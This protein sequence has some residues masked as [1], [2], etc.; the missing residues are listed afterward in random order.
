MSDKTIRLKT[1]R[2]EAKRK[3]IVS[4]SPQSRERW[5]KLNASLNDSYK[6]DEAVALNK[7]IED[8]RMADETGNY[9]TT[10]KI[11][12]TLSVKN[13][14]KNVKVKKRDGTAP[15][16]EQELLEEWKGFF[17]SLLNN[18]SGL[19]PPELPSPAKEDLSIFADPTTR[20]ET[21]KAIAAMKANKAAALDCAITAEALQGDGDHMLDVIHA[22]C[23]EVYSTL[24]PPRQWITNVIIPLP[25]K[26]D[27]SLMTNYRGISLMSIA[28]K[29][30][31]KILLN[32]IRPHVDPL[33][34]ASKP[35][36][37]LTGGSVRFLLF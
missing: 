22:F 36:R 10:W 34:T 27:L 6:V 13:S 2:D 17:S 23:S 21:E 25:K 26:G 11:I 5:R 15:S 32:R 33:G 8:L 16:S 3:Y 4:K 30:Y 28:A 24:S 1:E 31:N 12:H 7:Q 35:N 14:S 9:T 29:V 18:D 19:T 37:R 20:E